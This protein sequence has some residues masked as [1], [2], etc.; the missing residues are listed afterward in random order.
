MLRYSTEP[1][2]N[3]ETLENSNSTAKSAS[4]ACY[5]N[6]N[7]WIKSVSPDSSGIY[8][9]HGVSKLYLLFPSYCSLGWLLV[10]SK[11]FPHFIYFV[12]FQILFL[13]IIFMYQCRL[14]YLSSAFFHAPVITFFS[15]QPCDVVISTQFGCCRE[16]KRKMSA[17][18]LQN[19]DT[20]IRKPEMT[21][22][23]MTGVTWERTQ[24]WNNQHNG[25]YLDLK[26]FRDN[27]KILF[28][29]SNSKFF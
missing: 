1:G 10:P 28:R 5:R 12:V 17:E 26:L 29:N 7:S 8:S 2:I 4:T 9:Q 27:A 23:K 11:G 21:R 19:K 24:M 3:V 14:K 20:C 18:W 22:M 6:V 25:G 16:T 13:K 15:L